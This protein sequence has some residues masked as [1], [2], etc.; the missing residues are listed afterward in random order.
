M[1]SQSN[2]ARR[3][4]L[5]G[6]ELPPPLDK[7]DTKDAQLED[8][9]LDRNEQ[10]P[11]PVV[12]DRGVERRRQP[13]EGQ[14]TAQQIALQQMQEAQS[15]H[16]TIWPDIVPP[17][18]VPGRVQAQAERQSVAAKDKAVP[19]QPEASR[20]PSLQK[21]TAL[22]SLN[23]QQ[24]HGQTTRQKREV[25]VG[26]DPEPLPG[27]QRQGSTSSEAVPI[28]N[29]WQ[30]SQTQ[31]RARQEQILRQQELIRQQ[32]DR[33]QHLAL[34]AEAL[35]ACAPTWPPD[36]QSIIH[37]ATGQSQTTPQHAQAVLL[38]AQAVRQQVQAVQQ[39]G[40][41]ILQQAQAIRQQAGTVQQAVPS[42]P[43]QSPASRP[44]NPPSAAA[45]Y[46][47]HSSATR[48]ST[49]TVISRALKAQYPSLE[50]TVV[51]EHN[52]Q[53]LS[54]AAAGYALASPVKDADADP[55]TL[56][57][58][59]Y[60]PPARRLDG[61]NGTLGQQPI[62]SKY[63]YR[64]SGHELIVYFVDGRDGDS[65]Y[66]QIRNYYI[67]TSEPHLADHLIMAAGKWSD[68]LHEEILVFD[69]GAWQKS[70][71]LYASVRDARWENVILD[72]GMKKAVIEDHLSFFR[73]R[74]TYTGLKVPWKRGII[75]YGPPG[76]GK[77]ISI[78][79]TMN[80]LYRQSPEI[81][82]LYV[83]TLA[84][85]AGP[86]YSVRQIFAQARRYA[87][88]YLV[89]EDLDT[90]VSD[91]VRSYFLNEVDGLKNNDGIFMVGSTNHLDRLDPG[92]SK[93]P[94]RFDRKYYFPDPD[95]EQRVAYCHFWQKKLGDNDEI[96]FPDKLCKAIAEITDKFS[97]AYMQE[98]FVAALLAIASKSDSARRRAFSPEDGSG[99]DEWV[100]VEADDDDNDYDDDSDD[101]SDDDGD[102]LD[103]YVLWVE[104]QKQIAIL[105]E[106]M[107]DKS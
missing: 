5:G 105:R 62:F 22:Y 55:A 78:K 23:L 64:W 69:Q 77:T 37:S 96:E 13:T 12:N 21:L 83:R 47:D 31:A 60:V 92:I 16:R 40:Q 85:F 6:A 94:S 46:L 58:K 36:E 93:R 39:Q 82:T 17:S 32:Q 56:S 74:D 80:M 70:K 57:W 68:D 79:A 67:L 43:P 61:G 45:V 99:E 53:L 88:C 41:A 97:F 24:H 75:Y 44:H 102:D 14:Q 2:F 34:Q 4:G 100:G 35:R 8:P 19:P 25:Q 63:I 30:P 59:L 18:F 50:L 49:D 3:Y 101:G 103:E 48:V 89:F 27:I 29:P 66:P 11:A 90:I 65:Y 107:E 26:R 38:Q 73:S 71:E 84:S 91:S 104:M 86:E 10:P 33:Q 95:L 42:V 7:N 54:Y 51:A 52:C 9:F 87:P 15:N 72:E 20:Q 76:N 106:G 28:R 98:A 81:P 1:A